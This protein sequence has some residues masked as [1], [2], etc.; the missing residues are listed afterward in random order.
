L[1]KI[2]GQIDDFGSIME[3][4]TDEAEITTRRQP[5]GLRGLNRSK[6]DHGARERRTE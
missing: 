1:V 5:G 3:V 4:M 2:T 6:I